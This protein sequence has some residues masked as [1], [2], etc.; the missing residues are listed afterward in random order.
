MYGQ[1]DFAF[2]GDKQG[3]NFII[4]HHWDLG[5]GRSYEVT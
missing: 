5:N 3:G 2:E 4:A 1:V